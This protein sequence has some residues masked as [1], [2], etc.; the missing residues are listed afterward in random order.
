MQI[1]TEI[2]LP[3]GFHAKHNK[4]H[5]IQQLID[6]LI[7]RIQCAKLGLKWKTTGWQISK[8]RAGQPWSTV[9]RIKTPICIQYHIYTVF[10]PIYTVPTCSIYYTVKYVF[11]MTRSSYTFTKR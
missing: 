4:A 7:S 8:N 2:F 3:V 11:H 6:L 1:K 5:L 9:Y 10:I